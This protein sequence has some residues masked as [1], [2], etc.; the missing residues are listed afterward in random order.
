MNLLR[1][2]V[3]AGLSLRIEDDRIVATP[4]NAVT[5]VIEQAIRDNFALV[6]MAVRTTEQISADALARAARHSPGGVHSARK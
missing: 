2:I 3:D 6:K 5:P 4:A 1:T